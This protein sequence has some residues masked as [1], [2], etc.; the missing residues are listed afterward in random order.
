MLFGILWRALDGDESWG[1]YIAGV[2]QTAASACLV[3]TAPRE[4]SERCT[5]QRSLRV[6][7]LCEEHALLA[8]AFSMTR[9][10]TFRG[11]DDGRAQLLPMAFKRPAFLSENA[12]REGK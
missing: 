9:H 4:L 2:R 10:V 5:I 12:V 11:A 8:N 3:S 1:P 6:M 7:D